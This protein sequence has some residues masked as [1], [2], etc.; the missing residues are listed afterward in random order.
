MNKIEPIK[1]RQTFIL[2]LIVLL[3]AIIFNYLLPYLSGVLGAVTFYVLLV[4]YQRMLEVRGWKPWIAASLLIVISIIVIL[5]PVSLIV[6]LLSSK[7]SKFINNSEK[8]VEATK[9]YIDRFEE[10]IG[11]NFSQNIDTQEITAWLSNNLQDFAGGTFNALIAIGLLYFMLY[12]MLIERDI[13]TKASQAYIPLKKENILLIGQEVSDLVKSN[14]IGI[15]LV[16]VMQGI[17]A[18]IGFWI[19]GVSDPWFWFVVTSIGSMIPFVGTALGIVPVTI[20]LF[21]QGDSTE[22]IG[23]LIYG[24]TIVSATDNLFRFL[25]QK[26]LADLHPMITIIGV[27]VGVPIFGFIGLI[28]GPLLVSLFLLLVRIYR[29]E[30]SN[31]KNVL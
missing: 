23:I 30:Y 29:K 12:Y 24:A 25:I 14:A 3:F 10:Y 19:F 8:V 26:K 27:I 13:W 22:A 11:P 1:I 28:F 16:G 2:L 31:T 9:N 18:L 5:V 20:L 17:V 7:V 6:L 15:P 4:R 21:A